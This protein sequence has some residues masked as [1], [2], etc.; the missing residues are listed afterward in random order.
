[1]SG[2]V[3]NADS[4]AAEEFPEMLPEI[5]NEGTYIHE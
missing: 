3:V 2:K 1:M 4:G 5:I